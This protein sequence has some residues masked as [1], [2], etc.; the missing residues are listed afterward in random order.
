MIT[1]MQVLANLDG[2]NNKIQKCIQNAVQ[3]YQEKLSD[4]AA[5][6]SQSTKANYI[7]D[8][9]VEN[10]QKTFYGDPN[11]SVIRQR[12]MIVFVFSTDP[13]IILKFKKFNKRN[14]VAY[15]RTMQAFAFLNQ[16][17]ELFP[18]YQKQVHLHAGYKWNE[19]GT[20][21]ECLI[22]YPN[23]EGKHAWIADLSGRISA[24]LIHIVET[25]EQTQIPKPQIILKIKPIKETNEKN[26]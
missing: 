15:S 2:Y 17:E 14:R 6:I 7:R 25:Q 9:I 20:T 11:V 13:H 5:I 24:P 12:G 10:A 3:H 26:G 16:E 4:E 8:L 19:T 18:S 22:G 1:E 23:G 21:I